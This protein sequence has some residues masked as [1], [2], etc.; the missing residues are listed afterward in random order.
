MRGRRFGIRRDD[1]R[2]YTGQRD[3]QGWLL[4]SDFPLLALPNVEA[5]RR[6]L[7]RLPGALRNRCQIV[8][9]KL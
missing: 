9:V 6:R 1:G 3:R 8:G 7:E 5:A 2:Y 4:W